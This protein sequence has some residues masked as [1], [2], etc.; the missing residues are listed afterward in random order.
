MLGYTPL[1]RH[2]PCA[3]QAG[4]RSTSGRYASHWNAFLLFVK[5]QQKDRQKWLFKNFI[6]LRFTIDSSF[7]FLLK[8]DISVEPDELLSY[9]EWV[10]CHENL[11]DKLVAEFIA[12][13]RNDYVN[14]CSV[15]CDIVQEESNIHI[16]KRPLVDEEGKNILHMAC[17]SDSTVVGC[18]LITTL[19]RDLVARPCT[20]GPYRGATPLHIASL[21]GNLKLIKAMVEILTRDE[22]KVIFNS[23]A[24]GSFFKDKMKVGGFPLT[25]ALWAGHKEVCSQ[26]ILLG[27]QLDKKDV[28][29][30]QTAVHAVVHQGHHWP[31]LAVDMMKW[32]LSPTGGYLWWCSGKGFPE[33]A[34]SSYQLQKY[35]KYILK[36]TDNEGLTPLL[37][38]GKLG[39]P[40]II[41]FLTNVEGVYC[42]T[43]WRSPRA[44]H[45]QYD[46]KEIDPAINVGPNK[47][48]L[49]YITYMDNHRT[50]Q[51]LGVEPFRSLLKEKWQSYRCFFFAFSILHLTIMI[52]FTAAIVLTDKN[53]SRY[54]R[55]GRLLG[56][57]LVA[58]CSMVYLALEI[59]DIVASIREWCRIPGLPQRLIWKPDP[60][61][62]V[63]W[64]F[65]L[66][67]LATM[68]FRWTHRSEA[69]ISSVIAG[70]AGWYFLLGFT[71]MFR[72]TGFFTTI[73]HRV[74]TRDILRFSIVIGVMLLGFSL[75]MFVL[76]HDQDQEMRSANHEQYGNILVD[77][78]AMMVGI[79]DL[80]LP[81]QSPWRKFAT[82][83]VILFIMFFVLTMLNMLIAA[84]TNTYGKIIKRRD[85]VWRRNRLLSILI[86]ERRLC[87]PCMSHVRARYLEYDTKLNTWLFTI[88][89]IKNVEHKSL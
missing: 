88:E 65:C 15:L 86:A 18:H 2:P 76:L 85:D 31:E 63:G 11:P 19:G 35:Q 59:L 28:S 22:C 83:Y 10:T 56:E 68:L 34:I 77:M 36:L 89:E 73:V 61:R 75:G 29:N 54:Q 38:A 21:L 87:A 70:T 4:I 71:R 46:M 51:I 20:A 23:Q 62:P 30:G 26:L 72:V 24:N 74:L 42:H 80:E 50:V 44:S 53:E 16:L 55:N 33:G 37:L 41:K 12:A 69:D 81:L 8:D 64:I 49:E 52:I 58:G 14:R 27:A 79:K 25:I 57:A 45:I 82:I 60:F 7:R 1:G 84:M 39:V 47:S 43:L 3:V 17:F 67:A 13:C 32:V 9:R 6:S 40:E 66:F 5:F 78:F 48:L